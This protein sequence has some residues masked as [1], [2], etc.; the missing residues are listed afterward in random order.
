[1]VRLR[2]WS[3]SRQETSQVSRCSILRGGWNVLG[4]ALRDKREDHLVAF[5]SMLMQ[6]VQQS[7]SK[8]PPGGRSELSTADPDR[9]PSTEPMISQG[10]FI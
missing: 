7:W 3:V 1:M 9:D 8:C 4:A 6:N 5:P 10:W 2:L